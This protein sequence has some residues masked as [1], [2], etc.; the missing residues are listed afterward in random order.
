MIFVDS[1]CADICRLALRKIFVHLV[2]LVFIS[3][4]FI[5]FIILIYSDVSNF[6]CRCRNVITPRIRNKEKFKVKIYVQLI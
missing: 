6:T 4:S 2:S 1:I 3:L 5:L